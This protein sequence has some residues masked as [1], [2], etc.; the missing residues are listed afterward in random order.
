MSR[1]R[2]HLYKWQ[3]QRLEFQQRRERVKR[4]RA[5]VDRLN[6]QIGRLDPKAN[7][8][9]V[10]QYIARIRT[11]QQQIRYINVDSLC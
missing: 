5:E 2:K 1:N 7:H 8:K 10:K 3:R 11:L 9:Q 4:L 6:W